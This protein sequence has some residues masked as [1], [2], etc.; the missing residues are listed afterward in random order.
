MTTTKT[1]ASAETLVSVLVTKVEKNSDVSTSESERRAKNPKLQVCR[2]LIPNGH[3]Q[4]LRIV[5]QHVGFILPA[6][7]LSEVIFLANL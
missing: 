2:F 3:N 4:V 6:V 1:N 5:G 7:R